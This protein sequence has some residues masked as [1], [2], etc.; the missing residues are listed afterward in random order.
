MT[1]AADTWDKLFLQRPDIDLSGAHKRFGILLPQRIESVWYFPLCPTLFAASLDGY[2]D[3]TFAIW[4]QFWRAHIES[5]FIIRGIASD[6]NELLSP[7]ELEIRV[8]EIVE[9]FYP[10]ESHVCN[11]IR[12]L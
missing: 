10:L 5:H 8:D 3:E 4:L 7:S 6:F 9:E 2:A 1:F 11:G 12:G